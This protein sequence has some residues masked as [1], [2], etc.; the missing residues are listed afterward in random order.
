M[1]DINRINVLNK[2]GM[3]TDEDRKQPFVH[4]CNHCTFR[5]NVDLSGGVKVES[6]AWEE[7][8]IDMYSQ[9]LAAFMVYWTSQVLKDLN[10]FSGFGHVKFELDF[11]LI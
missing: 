9:D 5:T 11:K 7:M 1:K 2:E 3:L 10:G 8:T 4:G 6:Y